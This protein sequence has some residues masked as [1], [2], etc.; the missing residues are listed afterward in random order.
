MILLIMLAVGVGSFC[1]FFLSILSVDSFTLPSPRKLL[2]VPQNL[3]FWKFWR[4]WQHFPKSFEVSLM[5]MNTPCVWLNSAFGSSQIFRQP[6]GQ[7]I[8]FWVVY[9]NAKT[10]ANTRPSTKHPCGAVV[11]S[12]QH[13]TVPSLSLHGSIEAFL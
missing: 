9:K 6:N 11:L 5:P 3:K 2:R 1:R 7:K 8:V 4:F 12:L 13:Q 10:P